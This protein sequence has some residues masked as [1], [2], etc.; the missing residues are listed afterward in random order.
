MG[1]ALLCVKRATE[2]ERDTVTEK[3]RETN[4]ER[5]GGFKTRQR[6]MKKRK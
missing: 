3:E 6:K 4:R 5:G 2:R 1:R